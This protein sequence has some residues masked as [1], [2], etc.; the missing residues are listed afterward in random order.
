MILPNKLF[1]YNQSVL[2]KIPSFLESLD[3]PQ[4]PKELYLNM[5][6]LWMCWIAYTHFIKLRLI[7]KGES[8]NAKGDIL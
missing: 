3:R 4:T 5:W 7:R 6:N 2:S 1:S 8:I